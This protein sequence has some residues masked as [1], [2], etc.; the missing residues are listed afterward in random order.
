MCDDFEVATGSLLPVYPYAKYR[1][2]HGRSTSNRL[3]ANIAYST[4]K[5]KSSSKT[6]VDLL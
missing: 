3:G 6:G 5:G 4:L 2:E 1:N